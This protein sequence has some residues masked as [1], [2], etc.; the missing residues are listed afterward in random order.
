MTLQ[1][2]LSSFDLEQET[3]LY[4]NFAQVLDCVEK[5]NGPLKDS[6]IKKKTHE[7]TPVLIT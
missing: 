6:R 7:M 3:I 1:M 5:R 4:G 2:K